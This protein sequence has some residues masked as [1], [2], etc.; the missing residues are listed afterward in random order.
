MSGMQTNTC[1]CHRVQ[2]WLCSDVQLHWSFQQLVRHLVSP[3][4]SIWGMWYQGERFEEASTAFSTSLLL[5]YKPW[6]PW[7]C[8]CLLYLWAN[9]VGKKHKVLSQMCLSLVTGCNVRCSADKPKV[10]LITALTGWKTQQIMI[11]T[12]HNCHLASCIFN[13]N[14]WVTGHKCLMTQLCTAL[15]L[16]RLELCL[17]VGNSSLCSSGRGWIVWMKAKKTYVLFL[18]IFMWIILRCWTNNKCH[19]T[20]LNTTLVSPPPI[21]IS[22]YISLHSWLI[23][24]IFYSVSYCTCSQMKLLILTVKVWFPVM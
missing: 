8:S 23:T 12:R 19:M 6:C 5:L 10:N 24:C 15:P 13:W 3:S 14:T 16:S 2:C 9:I 17:W 20:V 21:F 11:C 7:H 22:L 4:T 18:V 1:C